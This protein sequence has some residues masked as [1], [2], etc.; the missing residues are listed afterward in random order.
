M[1]R[2]IQT[3]IARDTNRA[4][5]IQLFPLSQL[6]HATFREQ[7]CTGLI[8][9][10]AEAAHHKQRDS[11]RIKFTTNLAGPIDRGALERCRSSGRNATCSHTKSKQQ[12]MQR[13]HFV[14]SG[15]LLAFFWSTAPSTPA[16]FPFFSI[17]RSLKRHLSIGYFKKT[18]IQN[19]KF[20]P[21]LSSKSLSKDQSLPLR[22]SETSITRKCSPRTKIY[23]TNRPYSLMVTCRVVLV[24][25]DFSFPTLTLE[26]LTVP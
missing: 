20:C 2:E 11:G 16:Y 22:K 17:M 12:H 9:E 7:G 18:P 25:P 24:T 6:R 1:R 23:L 19:F 3:R 8:S 14:C 5:R 13:S 10:N 4:V 26:F 15:L 21:H